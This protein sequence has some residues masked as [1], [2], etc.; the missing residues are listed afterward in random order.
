LLAE[1]LP[2]SGRQI[3]QRRRARGLDVRHG[4]SWAEPGMLSLRLEDRGGTWEESFP[5]RPT[6][7]PTARARR[8]P[9]AAECPGKL[10]LF[11]GSWSSHVLSRMPSFRPHAG[12]TSGSFS[13]RL[14]E[15]EGAPCCW[16]FFLFVFVNEMACQRWRRRS[17]HP[18]LVSKLHRLQAPA[19]AGAANSCDP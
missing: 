7:L 18:V 9:D 19:P 8:L 17:F 1:G 12:A 3:V 11:S 14:L 15:G 10:F 6:V 13:K 2:G 16:P 4:L 5:V